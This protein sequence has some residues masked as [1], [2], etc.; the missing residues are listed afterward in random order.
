MA[1]LKDLLKENFSMV[2]G[3]VSTPAIGKGQSSLTQ[4]VEDNYGEI[5]EERVDAKKVIEALSQYNEIGKSL[6]TQDDLRETAEKLSNIAKLTKNHTLSE[7]EDWFDKVS[8]NRNMKELTNFSTQFGKISG[9]A[10]SIRERLATL[11]EDMGNILNRYYDIPEVNEVNVDEKDSKFN[12][13]VSEE[14]GEYQKFFQSALKKF[15]VSSPDE[16]DDESKKKL[17]NFVDKNWKAKK[18]T[19]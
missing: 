17:F 14:D 4:I 12:G 19:D 2:G 9:E 18:E 15:G 8:V 3:V 1:K 5:D 11:Y 10:Q 7:T 6:Y 16:L 13:T